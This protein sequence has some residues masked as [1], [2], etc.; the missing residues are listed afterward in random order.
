M[1]REVARLPGRVHL[2]LFSTRENNFDSSCGE[3]VVVDVVTLFSV[4][5]VERVCG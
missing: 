5:A 3:R 4:F 2:Y 1:D